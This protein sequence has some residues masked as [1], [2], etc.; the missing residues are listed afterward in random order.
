MSG[1][2]LLLSGADLA[3]A[4]ELR[5]SA[6]RMRKRVFADE[7]Q[8]DVTVVDGMEFDQ[9]DRPDT[10]YVLHLIDGEVACHWRFLPTTGPYMLSEVFPQHAPG[11]V[12]PRD[13]KIWEL[14]RFA[15]EM[16]RFRGDGHRDYVQTE[17]FC[18]FAEFCLLHGI[19]ELVLVQHPG[20]TRLSN[21]FF[22]RP[23]VMTTP[24]K[25]GICDAHTV[26]YRPAFAKDLAQS[27]D[28]YGFSAPLVPQF[29]LYSHSSSGFGLPGQV[30]A[31]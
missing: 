18:M 16:G 9:F 27:R 26:M 19:M 20:I 1:T 11:G 24:K 30:A 6:Y 23:H 17:M 14:S 29:N 21:S 12:I 15:M 10:A 31:E 3:N 4:P 28:L 7:M 25:T 8:W 2:T 5:N 13:P 22:G